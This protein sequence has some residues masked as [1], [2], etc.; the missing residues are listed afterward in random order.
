MNVYQIVQLQD[1]YGEIESR[2]YG[3]RVQN[4]V[5]D[6]IFSQPIRITIIL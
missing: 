6:M 3:N 5:V 1:Y 4:C 2:M